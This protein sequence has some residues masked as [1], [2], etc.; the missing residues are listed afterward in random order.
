MSLILSRDTGV[1]TGVSTQN[2]LSKS[3]RKQEITLCGFLILR[4]FIIR[5]H[6][7][8][9]EDTFEETISEQ[10]G[11]KSSTETITKPSLECKLV[12]SKSVILF[13]VL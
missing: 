2:L 4:Y 12:T 10:C 3:A 8:K 9:T 11:D 5:P 6:D 1:L 13:Q 7:A